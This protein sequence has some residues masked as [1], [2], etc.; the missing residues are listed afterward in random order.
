M[1]TPT[2]RTDEYIESLFVNK[3]NFLSAETGD[4]LFFV[5]NELTTLPAGPA[6]QVI[7]SAGPG[8]PLIFSPP[9]GIGSD[10]GEITAKNLKVDKLTFNS[11]SKIRLASKT[12]VDWLP[13]TVEFVGGTNS[14]SSPSLLVTE[15]NSGSIYVGMPV[16]ID[17]TSA[18]VSGSITGTVLTVTSVNSGTILNGH[19]L[20]GTGVTT[21][22]TITAFGTGSGGV[23]TYTVSIPQ[24]V[25]STSMQSR[26]PGLTISAFGIP[27]TAAVGYIGNFVTNPTTLLPELVSSN[28]FTRLTPAAVNLTINGTLPVGTL[29]VTPST[30]NFPPSGVILVATDMGPQTVTYSAIISDAF[31]GCS[32]GMGN[33]IIGGPITIQP[34]SIGTTITEIGGGIVATTKVVSVDITGTIYTLDKSLVVPESTIIFT[35]SASGD[36]GLYTMSGSILF[37][38]GTAFSGLADPG[39]GYLNNMFW[40]QASGENA[41]G[42][43]NTSIGMNALE[44][45]VDGDDNTAVGYKALSS[46]VGSFSLNGFENT[47][48]GSLAMRNTTTGSRNTSAGYQTLISNTVENDNTAMG[49]LALQNNTTSNTSAFGSQ[50]MLNNTTGTGNNAFGYKTLFTNTTGNDNMAIGQNAL[51]FLD[52]NASIA[53]HDNIAIGNFSLNMSVTSSENT[54]IGVNSL[55][56]ATASDNNVAVGN[57]TLAVLDVGLRNTAVGYGA[58]E[59]MT[60]GNDV[61]AVGYAAAQNGGSETT[62]VGAFSLMDNI[63]ELSTTVTVGGT[64]PVLTLTVVDTTGF[65]TSGSL[66]VET[67][68]GPTEIFYNG[69]TPT[70]FIQIKWNNSAGT[71]NAGALVT[72][73]GINNTALGW[74]TLSSN[75]SGCGNT[76]IGNNSM[77]AV[78]GSCNNT[79]VGFDTL[80]S[81][82]IG[83]KFNAFGTGALASAVGDHGASVVGTVIT[84]QTN[85]L[86]LQTIETSPFTLN[87]ISALEFPSSG[88]FNI[89]VS[90]PV[91]GFTICKY[92]GTTPT[93]FLGVTRDPTPPAI[94]ELIASTTSVLT[95]TAVNQ[96]ASV[97][98]YQSFPVTTPKLLNRITWPISNAFVVQNTVTIKLYQGKLTMAGDPAG[99]LTLVT[100]KVITGPISG[101]GTITVDFSSDNITLV[102]G[103]YTFGADQQANT[104][105]MDLMIGSENVNYPAILNY[106]SYPA[107]D[108]YNIFVYGMDDTTVVAPASAQVTAISGIL[109]VTSVNYGTVTVGQTLNWAGGSPGVI[110]QNNITGVGGIGTYLVS[111]GLSLPSTTFSLTLTGGC[112]FGSFALTNVTTGMSNIAIGNDSGNSLITGNSNIIIGNQADVQNDIS[113]AIV[114]GD[115]AIAVNPNRAMAINMNA[116]SV[117]PGVGIN[118]IINGS[119]ETI[120]LAQPTAPVTSVT[121]GGGVTGPSNACTVNPLAMAGEVIGTTS[122]ATIYPADAAVAIGNDVFSGLSTDT[123]GPMRVFQQ[124]GRKIYQ[125]RSYFPATGLRV[126]VDGFPIYQ[127]NTTGISTHSGYSITICYVTAWNRV[128]GPGYATGSHVSEI[129]FQYDN[130]VPD[131]RVVRNNT[132]TVGPGWVALGIS[133][134]TIIGNN[135]GIML[136]TVRLEC[137]FIE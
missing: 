82:L 6:G 41:T 54:A 10:T 53:G 66:T 9:G 59:M 109:D 21:G 11:D 4:T 30:D 13:L 61:T 80:S 133:G 78:T 70:S 112:A 26:P 118:C 119:L 92:T 52:G 45:I 83:S 51:E 23:G 108:A 110:I 120:S 96:G 104:F 117:M 94:E 79:A 116:S 25:S 137:F 2:L 67:T 111:D 103:H 135:S 15:V 91:P 74:S 64:I 87:V 72:A 106:F 68:L 3:L 127:P 55:M 29:N 36:V 48:T 17:G 129:H 14:I 24:T 35:G 16:S 102:P 40:G 69:I 5:G 28:V 90:S 75:I 128:L 88:A 130:G 46:L 113:G 19:E 105:F 22:T 101:G 49:A 89:Q 97:P 1:A 60:T 8:L 58:A 71:I 63:P 126:L 34:I 85:T 122:S 37:P 47:A 76:A 62:A 32:G 57:E 132:H 39:V 131:R 77:V 93:S 18:F 123:I 86:A 124:Y 134:N 50:A 107:T 125:T 43:Q 95:P 20:F 7:T 99:Y 98:K 42:V 121:M 84:P 33:F 114:I 81:A 115:G 73:G 56:M 136:Y 44:N 12:I 27:T 38:T 100:T 31:V 65:P